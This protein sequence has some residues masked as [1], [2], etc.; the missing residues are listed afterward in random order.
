MGGEGHFE[1]QFFAFRRKVQEL[2]GQLGREIGAWL[3]R[4]PSLQA[5]LRIMELFQWSSRRDTVRVR[6]YVQ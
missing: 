5:K 2:E 1:S 6:T 4:S 3:Q